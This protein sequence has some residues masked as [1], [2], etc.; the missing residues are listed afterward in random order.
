MS[1]TARVNDQSLSAR[2]LRSA[3]EILREENFPITGDSDPV[4]PQVATSPSMCVVMVNHKTTPPLILSKYTRV[5]IQ[6]CI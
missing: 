1:M 5:L 3:G 6:T 2:D 4:F